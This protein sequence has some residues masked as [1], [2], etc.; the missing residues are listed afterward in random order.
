MKRAE[1]DR[2]FD[3]IVAFA[4]FEKFLDTPVKHYSSGMYVRLAFAVAA[5][6]EPEILLVDEVLAVGDVAFQKKCLGKMGDVAREGR[7]VLFVSHNMAAVRRLCSHAMLLESGRKEMA[8]P[9]E[10]VITRY[11]A[12]GTSEMS[13]S[14]ALPPGLPDAPGAGTRLR[15]FAHDGTPQAQFRLG[16]PW[17]IVLEFELFRP[18]SHV[19]AAVGLVSL[20]SVPI[21]TY[22]SEPQDLIPGR[23]SV[24]FECDVPLGGRDFRFNVGLSS[25]ERPFYYLEGVGHVSISRIAQ[26]EQPVRAGGLLVSTQRC[27]I[28]PVKSVGTLHGS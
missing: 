9:T 21:I 28:R 13:T 10:S 7:T 17:R 14:A 4:E 18:V 23:Y 16:E 3:E 27:A 12:A 11:L 15:L 25:Y 2:K 19:I 24:E 1:I 5:H 8:G 26:G 20:D 6:L 22:W